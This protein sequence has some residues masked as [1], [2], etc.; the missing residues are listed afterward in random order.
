MVS[1]LIALTLLCGSFKVL[2]QHFDILASKQPLQSFG[3]LLNKKTILI[4][5]AFVGSVFDQISQSY[6][7]DW[8]QPILDLF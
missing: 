3:L 1:S 8:V 2:G 6:N 7:K 5:C 4:E